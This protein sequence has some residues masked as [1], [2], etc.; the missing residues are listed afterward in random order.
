M[1]E[2]TDRGATFEVTPSADA[3]L[4]PAERRRLTFRSPSYM[5][6][7]RLLERFRRE[8]GT[9]GAVGITLALLRGWNLTTD[10]PAAAAAFGVPAPEGGG[11]VALPVATT[12]DLLYEALPLDVV[13]EVVRA[14]VD[15]V[16]PVVTG[17]SGSPSGSPPDGSAGAAPTAGTAPTT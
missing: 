17:N 6:G 14:V 4:P 8:D 12:P 7:V 11:E 10:D 1:A 13:V 5:T 16:Y 15:H 9:A 3:A 2:I